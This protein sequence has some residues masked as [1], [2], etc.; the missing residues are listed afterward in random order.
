MTWQYDSPRPFVVLW[1]SPLKSS[2]MSPLRACLFPPALVL[3]LF[4]ISVGSE[5]RAGGVGV[6]Q[7]LGDA[8]SLLTSDGRGE[9]RERE[10]SPSDQGAQAAF[11]GREMRE[12][13]S[14]AAESSRRHAAFVCPLAANG[15]NT[16]DFYPT[17]TLLPDEYNGIR[18]LIAFA[19]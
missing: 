15:P 16:Q 18:W 4:F 6:G 13:V 2:P 17:P 12:F 9:R 14:R 19:F 8:R 7:A 3:L 10:R 5:V 1:G 11:E